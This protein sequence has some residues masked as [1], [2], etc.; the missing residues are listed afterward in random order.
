MLGV[1]DFAAEIRPRSL[2][3]TL[4]D[5]PDELSDIARRG[6]RAYEHIRGQIADRIDEILDDAR[7]RVIYPERIARARERE[8]KHRTAP[9]RRYSGGGSGGSSS[10][11]K[12][13]R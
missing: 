5:D 8:K 12:A 9:A 10:G 2:L 4:P 13:H 6:M 3:G 7:L 11:E 1:R